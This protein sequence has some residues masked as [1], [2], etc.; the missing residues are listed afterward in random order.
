MPKAELSPLGPPVPDVNIIG[1]RMK[2][3]KSGGIAPLVVPRTKVIQAAE[4]S[5]EKEEGVRL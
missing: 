1:V 4:S 5:I 3:E 2:E